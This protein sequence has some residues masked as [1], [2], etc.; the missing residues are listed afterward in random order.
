MGYPRRLKI[1]NESNVDII[2]FQCSAIIYRLYQLAYTKQSENNNGSYF[3][4]NIIEMKVY[5][6]LRVH[7]ILSKNDII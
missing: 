7:I 4:W 3:Y 1:L 6:D 5:P 2:G